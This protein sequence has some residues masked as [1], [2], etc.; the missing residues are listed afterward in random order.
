MKLFST[1]HE[2]IELNDGIATV[3]IT[4]HA[5]DQLGDIVYVEQPEIGRVVVKGESV[6][7]VESTK[8]VSDIYS[9]VAGEVVEVNQSPVDDPS[10]LNADPQGSAWLF[11]ISGVAESDLA[12]LMDA[13]SYVT[14]CS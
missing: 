4:D 3:G 1:D 5:Q 12:G 8:S 13:D 10:Q 11:R 2:W 9:P 6:A 7:I 14:F